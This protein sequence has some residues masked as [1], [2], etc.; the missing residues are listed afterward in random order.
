MKASHMNERDMIG[1][2]GV[3]ATQSS[4]KVSRHLPVIARRLEILLIVRK[5]YCDNGSCIRRIFYERI[6]HTDCISSRLRQIRPLA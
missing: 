5:Y 1:T 6:I 2:D 4:G 3:H